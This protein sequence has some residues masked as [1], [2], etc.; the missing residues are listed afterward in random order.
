[1]NHTVTNTR[2]HLI[3]PCT[4]RKSGS[5]GTPI[6]V[7][8]LSAHDH[9]TLAT[10]WFNTL[11]S[12]EACETPAVDL[13]AGGAW[14]LV[15]ELRNSFDN[16][17]VLSAGYGFINADS[18]IK[19]YNVTFSDGHNES[20]PT[21]NCTTKK[22]ANM[23]WWMAVNQNKHNKARFDGGI[24]K[25]LSDN[26]NDNFLFIG[27]KNYIELIVNE[28]NECIENGLIKKEK[29]IIMSAKKTDG[30]VESQTLNTDSSLIQHFKCTLANLN[31]KIAIYILNKKTPF[32]IEA[33]NKAISKIKVEPPEKI[34]KAKLSD[35]EIRT[36]II[37]IL[38]EHGDQ[39][40]SKTKAI[41]IFR[42][43]Y[44]LS[45]SVERFTPIYE[46]CKAQIY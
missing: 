12:S 5:H 4:S 34:K 2:S 26:C 14:S 8:E 41:N 31:Y 36:M 30:Q 45:C 33:F 11:N 29:I 3:T 42:N 20:I 1:M 10:N 38:L 6:K 25:L 9:T 15:K 23:K 43:T 44:N 21:L 28:I 40:K 13:Y 22:E 39:A 37:K 18:I 17:W 7:S 32:D 46:S 19:P 16:Q 35:K 24:T 27:S